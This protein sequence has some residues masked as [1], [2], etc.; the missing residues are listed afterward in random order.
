M[1]K[2]FRI[3][4]AITFATALSV[5][6]VSAETPAATAPGAAGFLGLGSIPTLVL[7]LGLLGVVFYFF[8]Y[9]PQKKQEKQVHEMRSNLSVGDEVCT[10]G[11]VLGR[12]VRI[13]DD[14]IT[15]E[16]GSDKTKMKVYNWA[17]REVI[18]PANAEEDVEPKKPE[19]EK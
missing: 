8:M 7:T 2:P 5:T 17:I 3:L 1:K 16:L 9:R 18:L 10:S 12:I 6:A 14:I 19:P 11:G 4:L 15:L 13:K